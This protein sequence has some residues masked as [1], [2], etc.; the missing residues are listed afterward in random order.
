MS[1]PPATGAAVEGGGAAGGAGAGADFSGAIPV[2]ALGPYSHHA[3]VAPYLNVSRLP[4]T[5]VDDVLRSA[6][7]PKYKVK[8]I[9][10]FG[11]PVHL[12]NV[13]SAV[14]SNVVALALGKG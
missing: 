10:T 14:E 4:R 1:A 12:E 7:S 13:V 11:V 8:P 9:E 3:R 6:Y 2:S 5:S